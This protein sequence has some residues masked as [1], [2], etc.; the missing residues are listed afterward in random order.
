MVVLALQIV[1]YVIMFFVMVELWSIGELPE[2]L[3]HSAVH[4][5]FPLYTIVPLAFLLSGSRGDHL[6]PFLYAAVLF[7][8][9]EV[10]GYWVMYNLFGGSMKPA[11]YFTFLIVPGVLILFFVHNMEFVPR[12]YEPGHFEMLRL[13]VVDYA[14]PEDGLD[15]AKDIIDNGDFAEG[16]FIRFLEYVGNWDDEL[17]R[18]ARARLRTEII[19]ESTQDVE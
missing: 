7:D 19:A 2:Y 12:N 17:G 6:K 5:S 4:I 15:H 16:F 13:E 18:L 3:T 1:Y 10:I 14:T 8:F 11:L 9:G